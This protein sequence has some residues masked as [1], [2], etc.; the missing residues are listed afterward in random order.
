MSLVSVGGT[1]SPALRG[2]VQGPA[3]AK[4]PC[5]PPGTAPPLQDPGWPSRLLATGMC[6]RVCCLQVSGEG[7]ITNECAAPE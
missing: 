4:D 1:P 6:K 5:C 3:L 2:R 7:Q